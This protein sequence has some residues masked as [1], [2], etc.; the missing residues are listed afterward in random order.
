MLQF[1]LP[2]FI[3]VGKQK[4]L[5]FFRN[6]NENYEILSLDHGFK[7]NRKMNFYFTF[8]FLKWHQKLN[9]SF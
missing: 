9:M 1:L 2:I 4:W 5:F 8:P 6:W 7:I 3:S